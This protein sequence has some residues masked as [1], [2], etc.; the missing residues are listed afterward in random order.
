MLLERH[1]NYYLEDGPYLGYELYVWIM[2][3]KMKNLENFQK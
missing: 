3:L 1:I 2:K